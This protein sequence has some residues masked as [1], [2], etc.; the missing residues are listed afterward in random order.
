MH[1]L[2]VWRLVLTA[3]GHLRKRIEKIWK[4]HEF[5]T[6]FDLVVKVDLQACK[7]CTF[8]ESVSNFLPEKVPYHF[9]GQPKILTLLWKF[10]IFK[11][12]A[13]VENLKIIRSCRKIVGCDKCMQLLRQGSWISQKAQITPHYYTFTNFIYSFFLWMGKYLGHNL[14]EN[15]MGD[16]LL[17]NDVCIIFRNESTIY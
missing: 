17:N 16:T 3:T 11:T 4:F 15:Y 13:R 7:S 6:F 14:M 2:Y 5:F 9:V 10:W 8:L 12:N 1:I